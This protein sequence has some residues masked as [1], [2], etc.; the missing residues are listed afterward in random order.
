M[1]TLIRFEGTLY[2]NTA[3]EIDFIGTEKAKEFVKKVIDKGVEDIEV[4]AVRGI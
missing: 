2:V 3:N 4:I 1:K